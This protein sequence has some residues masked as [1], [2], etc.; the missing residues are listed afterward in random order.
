MIRFFNDMQ[1]SQLDHCRPTSTPPRLA[2]PQLPLL[3]RIRFYPLHSFILSTLSSLCSRFPR[4]FYASFQ[5]ERA[6]IHHTEY[7]TCNIL[8]GT[9]SHLT[10]Y[11]SILLFT[12]KGNDSRMLRYLLL[13]NVNTPLEEAQILPLVTALST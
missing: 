6:I 5:P 12:K 4:S 2:Q 10:L 1:L 13:F 8:H 9:C 3:S 7:F 11:Y